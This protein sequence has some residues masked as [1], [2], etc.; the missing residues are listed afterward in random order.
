MKRI[1]AAPLV[2]ARF[3]F[4][5]ICLAA[6]QIWSNKMRSILTIIGI[7]IGVAAVI[8]V[9]ASLSGLKVKVLADLESFGT[10][11]VYIYPRWPDK[12][13]K[14][15]ASW[16]TIRF[17]PQQFDGL[18]DHCP[19]VKKV[20]R[21]CNLGTYKIRYG[22][23]TA[24]G[25]NLMG[26]EPDYHL[27]EKKPVLLG[28]MFTP[29]DEMQAM[30]VCKIGI[31]LRDK[32]NLPRDCT[33]EIIEVGNRLFRIVGVMEKRPD[34]AMI[35]AGGSEENLFI[36]IPFKT[37]LKIR[38]T[39]W[40]F[41]IAEAR[42][43]ELT[44]EAQAEIKFFLRKA[45]QLKPGEPDTFVVEAIQSYIDKFAQ[46]SAMITLVASGIVGISLIV[47]GVGIMNIMLVSVSERTRE[48]GLRKAVGAKR[49]AILMQFLVEAVVLCL[50]GG[51]LG[52]GL[53]ELI[54]QILVKSTP[55]LDKTYIP[56]WAILISFGFAAMV[57]ICFGFFPA[58]KAA[59]LDPIEALRHE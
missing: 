36:F 4:Q 7:I 22:D 11:N 31:D 5:S 12:G 45:K 2:F 53:G 37:A 24:D 50:M 38:N 44:E 13:P 47:G 18:L 52:I 55:Y 39:P 3:I 42:T 49:S 21:A 51:L 58:V 17:A 26:V 29:I 34:T 28:R 54:T 41:A 48:I 30:S 27:I 6:A 33:G 40:V 46:I 20:G 35:G 1:F 59:R 15:K 19:S 16:L 23:K 32:L 57:G 14:K 25:I 10:N 9:I 43:T 56:A 8:S